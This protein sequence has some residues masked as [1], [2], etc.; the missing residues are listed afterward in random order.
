ML[1]EL[2]IRPEKRMTDVA[3]QRVEYRLRRQH[4]RARSRERLEADAG[5]GGAARANRIAQHR[6]LEIIAQRGDGGLIY[7]DGRLDSAEQDML[8]VALTGQ[9]I[10]YAIV[11]VGRKRVFAPN[12]GARREVNQLRRRAAELLRNLLRECHG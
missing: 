2:G 8:H 9:R 10:A 1:Y 11:G 4:M 5:S 3:N 7:A 6:H 12:R